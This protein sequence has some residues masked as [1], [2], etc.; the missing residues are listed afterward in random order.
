MLQN[1]SW[2]SMD[3]KRPPKLGLILTAKIILGLGLH[4]YKSDVKCWGAGKY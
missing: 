2:L 4:F 3:G 1:S